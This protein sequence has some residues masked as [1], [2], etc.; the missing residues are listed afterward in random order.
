[1]V[2]AGVLV[3]VMEKS[4][5]DA[6]DEPHV[7]GDDDDVELGECD[8][9]EVREEF[10]GLLKDCAKNGLDPPLVKRA[11]GI[12]D[13]YE[14]CF[15]TK[16]GSPEPLRVP[17]LHTDLK[18]DAKPFKC[19]PRNY[20]PDQKAFMDEMI[21]MLRKNDMVY[22]NLNSRWASP[23]LITKRPNGGFR[24]VVD[25][26]RASFLHNLPRECGAVELNILARFATFCRSRST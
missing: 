11:R 9:E 4:E 17:P 12:L 15:R 14:G 18:T 6:G 7:L 26:R 20:R 2:A 25:A 19:R 22:M 21:E 8:V 16:T 5:S 13:R 23:V 10:N 3:V 1:M 24:M